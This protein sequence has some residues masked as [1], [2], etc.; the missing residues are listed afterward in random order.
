MQILTISVS[1]LLAVVTCFMF[2]LWWRRRMREDLERD[3]ILNQLRMEVSELIIE[4]NGTTERNVALIE[5][6]IKKLNRVLERASKIQ[7]V[8]D[9]QKEKRET[10]EYTYS[11]LGKNKPL[12]IQLSKEE[13]VMNLSNINPRERALALYSRGKS[14][15]A[16]ANELGMNHGEIE[17]IINLHEKNIRNQ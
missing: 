12:D 6:Q 17:L 9:I 10:I 5:T 7:K 1:F 14:T 8:L 11:T 4:L 16:I 3:A 15:E 13:T 2:T